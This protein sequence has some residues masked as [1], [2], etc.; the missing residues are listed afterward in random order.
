MIRHLAMSTSVRK[1]LLWG[2]EKTDDPEILARDQEIFEVL[3]AARPHLMARVVE[4]VRREE[5]L[6][7]RREGRLSEPIRCPAAR[8]P[9]P[10]AAADRAAD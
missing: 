8:P 4:E 2:F 3:L 7:G 5:R 1:E 9:P 6:E 10:A